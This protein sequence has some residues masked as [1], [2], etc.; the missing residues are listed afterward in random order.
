MNCS[1]PLVR[2]HGLRE[3]PFVQPALSRTAAVRGR[4]S[5]LLLRPR[6]ADP[7]PSAEARRQP[8][9]RGRRPIRLRQIFAGEGR[10]DSPA[11]EGERGRRAD[12]A[13]CAVPT[14]GPADRGT[15]QGA[16][17]ACPRRRGGSQGAAPQPACRHAVPQ[18]PGAGRGR[19]R[20]WP[21]LIRP[22]AH[23]R[24]SIRGNLPVRGSERQERRRGD[25]L[26]AAADRGGQC[27]KPERST[28]S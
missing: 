9:R 5:G 6:R 25:R 18:Q 28:S 8:P 19:Q 26:R 4:R 1:R 17:Q 3:R 27:G 12:L 22:P 7:R 20:A 15:R 16:A 24:R 14:A 10:P 23:H 13:R 21:W 2:R 11:R